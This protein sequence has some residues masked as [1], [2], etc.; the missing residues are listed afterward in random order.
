MNF[1]IV[2]EGMTLIAFIVMIIGSKQKRE[3]GWKV[4]SGLLVLVGAIQCSGMSL[5]VSFPSSCPHLTRGV[6]AS[7]WNSADLLLF[8]F[9]GLPL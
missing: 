4:L 6:L 3:T 7:I 9:T 2:I 5:I 8:P 1:A